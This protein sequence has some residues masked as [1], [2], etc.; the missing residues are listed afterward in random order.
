VHGTTIPRPSRQVGELLVPALAEPEPV[1]LI[2]PVDVV[3]PELP[4]VVADP[5]VC[6]EPWLCSVL[7][8]TQSMLPACPLP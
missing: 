7:Q 1:A 8:F 4:A 3:A 5:D 2:W 6:A